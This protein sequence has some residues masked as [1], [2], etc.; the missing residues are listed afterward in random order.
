[1]RLANY[2]ERLGLDSLGVGVGLP[3]VRA[4]KQQQQR[5]VMDSSAVAFFLANDGPVATC[6]Y[7]SFSLPLQ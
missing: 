6:T 5:E 3:Q 7:F 1:V 4:K 2:Y